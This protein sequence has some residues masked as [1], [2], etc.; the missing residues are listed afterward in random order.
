MRLLDGDIKVFAIARGTPL[1][2]GKPRNYLWL[3]RLHR[4]YISDEGGHARSREKPFCHPGV[5][6][7]CVSRL[8]RLA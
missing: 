6:F 3:R 7:V 2:Q 8:G 4:D 1:W 5:M